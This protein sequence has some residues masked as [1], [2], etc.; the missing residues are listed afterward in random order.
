[1]SISMGGR[2]DSDEKAE[3][4]KKAADK[5]STPSA[6][7]AGEQ[8]SEKANEKS[9][10]EKSA[11][12]Q[13]TSEKAEGDSSEKGEG[14]APLKGD[15][16]GEKQ[17]K[18]K[19]HFE[20]DT[21]E[22]AQKVVSEFSVGEGGDRKA[23]V[24]NAPKPN[25][26]PKERVP[27]PL[28]EVAEFLPKTANPRSEARGA[29]DIVGKNEQHAPQNVA[30]KASQPTV[31][32][33][34]FAGQPLLVVQPPAASSNPPAGVGKKIVQKKAIVKKGAKVSI[35]MPSVGE[36]ESPARAVAVGTA[37]TAVVTG[38]GAAGNAKAAANAANNSAKAAAN[39]AKA[40]AANNS[41]KAAAIKVAAKVSAPAPI[42]SEDRKTSS[43]KQG[44]TVETAGTRQ[45][46][47]AETSGDAPSKAP[48]GPPPKQATSANSIPL[49]GGRSAAGEDGVGRGG[50]KRLPDGP[51]ETRRGG[52]KNS[53]PQESRRPGNSAERGKPT[54]QVGSS[55][56]ASSIDDASKGKNNSGA[57]Q[58]DRHNNSGKG[59]K[60]NT[61]AKSRP[62]GKSEP[63]ASN[64]Q[65]PVA[66]NALHRPAARDVQNEIASHAKNEVAP[67]TTEE[68]R[69]THPKLARG[70]V[71]AAQ[72]QLFSA[73]TSR[74]PFGAVDWLRSFQAKQRPFVEMPHFRSTK[75]KFPKVWPYCE[76]SF[77]KGEP[78]V[79][80]YRGIACYCGQRQS[81]V[82][83]RIL[84][85]RR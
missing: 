43:E 4:S 24:K 3:D 9:P 26:G 32:Q 50:T 78:M 52:R 16:G 40:N 79:L 39:A 71:A 84:S 81:E 59:D 51:L 48:R 19:L 55:R 45:G 6:E 2:D 57:T 69:R 68:Y 76:R 14:A 64:A 46:P 38:A 56:L 82:S 60:N 5:S 67:T 33:K 29:D 28:D 72:K 27:K 35:K 47:Q 58:S 44:R 7:K 15:A 75:M 37:G 80:P 17:K 13:S 49:G 42:A 77:L 12:E 41:A 22:F 53:R 1:M 36:N 10:A 8:S 23:G 30:E 31:V 34:T 70:S 20:Q 74:P 85:R 21:P 62:T 63:I 25:G 73:T 11:G 61:R 65:N 54:P 66:G 18:S 83:K